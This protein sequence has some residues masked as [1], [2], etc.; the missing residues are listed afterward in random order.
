[1]NSRSVIIHL[2]FYQP[3]REDPWLGEVPPE[4]SAAPCHDW[5]ERVTQECYRPMR[6]AR[7]LDGEGRVAAAVN[8][9]ELCSFNV[10]PTLHRWL[11]RAAPDVD[12]AMRLADARGMSTSG[13]GRALAQPWVHAILPLAHPTDRVTLL[14]WGVDDFRTRFG[15]EPRAMWLPETAVDYDTL[16]AMV[17]AGITATILSPRQARAV[18][19]PIDSTSGVS[20]EWIPKDES[21]LDTSLPYRVPLPSGRSINV[22]F[23]DGPV[24]RGIA[25]EGLLESGDRLNDRVVGALPQDDP[26]RLL[27]LATDGETFGHHHRF[28]EMALA[29]MLQR[30]GDDPE[31]NV[32]DL[33]TFLE[34]HPPQQEA[35]IISPSAWSCAHGVERWRSN[36]GCST[37]GRSGW[38]QHWRAPLRKAID[39]LRTPLVEVFERV[40]GRLFRDPWAAREEFG[41]ALSEA[42]TLDQL[43]DRHAKSD[44]SEEDRRCA[45]DLLRAQFH[46]LQAT[47]SCGWFFS[48]AAGIETQIVLRQ[49]ARAIELTE[50]WAHDDLEGEFVRWLTPMRANER[51]EG[52]GAAIWARH[53]VPSRVK[54]GLQISLSR[55]PGGE[56]AQE[57]LAHA[58][59]LGF[60]LHALGTHRATG[61]RVPHRGGRSPRAPGTP[62]G[63]AR[64]GALVTRGTHRCDLD[65]T[66]C[67]CAGARSVACNADRWL[68][69]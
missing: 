61:I 7:I 69:L 62:H 55:N 23:F 6:A 26:N 12:D 38:Q 59:R 29:W 54:H 57:R 67:D 48:D 49:A 5:N 22:A 39:D 31:V 18:R 21:S 9:Y 56:I 24:S 42:E 53:V 27:T 44:L 63:V 10:Y 8:T 45:R 16:E 3:P 32:T 36:C 65:R 13:S 43:I 35:E 58:E 40:G 46:Y 11:Q 28:G 4:P 2:H 64:A 33:V 66:E 15:R 17:D 50:R 41:L 52:D 20:P 14:R 60:D 25:F 1:M 37:G 47:T 51:H 30:L 34:H 68:S 19:A